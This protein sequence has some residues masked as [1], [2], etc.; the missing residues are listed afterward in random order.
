MQYTLYYAIYILYK[1]FS[2]YLFL[3]FYQ[4]VFMFYVLTTFVLIDFAFL[5]FL[6]TTSIKEFIFDFNTA[7][8][9]IKFTLISSFILLT[10]YFGKI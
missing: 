10:T 7:I 9:Q 6:L 4:N 3:F 8:P 2:L 5:F 1:F